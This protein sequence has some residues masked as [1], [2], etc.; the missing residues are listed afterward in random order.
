MKKQVYNFSAGPC[1]LPKEVYDKCAAEMHDWNGTGLSVME[2]SHRSPDF[3][4]ISEAAK[5]NLRKFLSVPD[6]FKI[7]FFQGGATMQYAAMV[8]NLMKEG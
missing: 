8:K 5:S 7:F 6:N 1:L 3:V 2:M 4:K